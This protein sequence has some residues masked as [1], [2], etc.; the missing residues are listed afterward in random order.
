MEFSTDEHGRPVAKFRRGDVIKS[1]QLPCIIDRGP[2]R[3]GESYQKG[4]AVS[5]G[6]GLWIAQEETQDKP[7]GGKGWRLAVKKGRDGKDGVVKEAK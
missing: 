6:G 3:T 2:F 7:D 4:D 5:Y 1:I